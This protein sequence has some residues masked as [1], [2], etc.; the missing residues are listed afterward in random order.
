MKF[1]MG[2]TECGK[3]STTPCREACPA[4]V[5]VPRY[6]RYIREGD[7]DGALAVIRERIPFPAVCGHACVHPCESKCARVQFDQPVA[8]RMLKRAAAEEAEGLWKQKARAAAPTGKKVAVIGAGPGGLTAAYYLSGLG[9]GVTVFEALPAPGGMMRYGIP[10]YRLPNH[11]LDGE[12]EVITG[13]GVEIRTNTRISTLGQLKEFDAVFIASGA[14]N[15]SL[16]GVE[17]ESPATVVDGIAFLNEVNS[18]K[19]VSIENKVVVVGGGNTAIDAARTSVRLGAGEVRLVYR[20]TRD[21]MP[22]SPEEVAEAVEE[23]VLMEFLAAP[24]KL[25]GGQVICSR[26]K[27]GPKDK[28]GRPAPVPVPDS[29]FPIQCD[30][31]IAAVGQGADAAALG[32]KSAAGGTIAV[33]SQT[34]ETSQKGVF[35]AGD[36]VTGPSSIIQAIA[37]GRNVASSIDSFLGGKGDVEEVFA[38]RDAAIFTPAPMGTKRPIIP[39]IPLGNRLNSFDLVEKGYD[40]NAARKEARRCLACDKREFKV[41]VD[42]KACKECGYCKEVCTLDIFRPSG[43]FN[44]RGYRPMEVVSSERCVGCQRC[45]FICPDFAISIE[46][47]G[48]VD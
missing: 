21:E 37:Q 10:Q 14:W 9:H 30:T 39:A 48:G 1:K 47:V 7:F 12:I 5:D 22:A 4:G 13:R 19:K 6:I 46:K 24:V 2:T 23:G 33:N 35:A 15:S 28:S 11:V 16:I 36:C 34:L 8:I 25:A 3:K 42:L 29:Q 32:L 17:G 43:S 31:I 38:G 44:D 45:F 26:M 18:G 41:E 20:R 40:H 27:L